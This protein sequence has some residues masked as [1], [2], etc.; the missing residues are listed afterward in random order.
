MF[1]SPVKIITYMKAVARVIGILVI[2]LVWA[3]CMYVGY[4]VF[5]Y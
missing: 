2:V 1:L 4:H 3:L 5:P